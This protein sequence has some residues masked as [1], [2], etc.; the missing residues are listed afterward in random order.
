M[1]AA[2]TSWISVALVF[3]IYVPLSAAFTCGS[4][5]VRTGITGTAT[6]GKQYSECYRMPHGTGELRFLCK[7]SIANFHQFTRLHKSDVVCVFRSCFLLLFFLRFVALLFKH[8]VPATV[9]TTAL[10]QGAPRVYF[11]YELALHFAVDVPCRSALR[12]T[13]DKP[14]TVKTG[15]VRVPLVTRGSMP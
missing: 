10:L 11:A 14:R 5:P 7:Y 1:G 13:Q 9:G 12:R 8:R 3:L 15:N 6:T 4:S 2:A